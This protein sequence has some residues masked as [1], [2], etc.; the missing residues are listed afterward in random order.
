MSRLVLAG[1]LVALVGGISSARPDSPT[2]VP[3]AVT[4]WGLKELLEEQR[5]AKPRLPPPPD[6]AEEKAN[7]RGGAG[8]NR[9]RKLLDPELRAMWPRDWLDANMPLT[10]EMR[11]ELLWISSRVNNCLY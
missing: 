10:K 2:P 6:T 3:V 8:Q 11:N 7:G 1:L 5:S 4:R 9:M